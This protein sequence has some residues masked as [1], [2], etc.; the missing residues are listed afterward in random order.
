MPPRGRHGGGGG[1][2]QAH[3]GRGRGG[4][5][6]RR[7][8]KVI[9]LTEED[10]G[11]STFGLPSMN[12]FI[13]NMMGINSGMNPLGMPM[14]NPFVP[15][16]MSTLLDPQTVGVYAPLGAAQTSDSS[17]VILAMQ[18][19]M[20]MQ[21]WMR[22]MNGS[23]TD[24]S[25]QVKMSHADLQALKMQKM[26]QQFAMLKAMQDQFSQRPRASAKESSVTGSDLSGD[27]EDDDDDDDPP[28]D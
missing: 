6:E 8:I 7:N 24:K 13:M 10:V 4:G 14:I 28:P 18:Q 26:Q 11:A 1:G 17:A 3:A 23:G 2:K 21:Q 25:V 20:L 5:Q 15:M 12:P 19:Q 9:D 27:A 22:Q 16:G